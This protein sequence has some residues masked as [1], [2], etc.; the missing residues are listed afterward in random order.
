MCYH[1]GMTTNQKSKVIIV[2]GG[3][4]GLNA[5]QSLKRANVD[6]LVI[7]K[8]NHHLFQPLLYQVASAALSPGDI[9]VP[10]REVL[11]KQANATVILADVVMID[12][13]KRLVHA[14]NGEQY[15]Y[16]YLI[17]APGTTHSY[18]GHNHWEG[19]A[20]G[21]KTVADAIR[22]RERI[23]VAFELAEKSSNPDEIA[24]FLRFVIVGGGPTGCEMAGAIAEIAT[25][26]LFRNFRHINPELSEIYLIEGLPE[27]LPSFPP[28]LQLKAKQ[29]LEKLGVRVRL[30]TRV[31]DVTTE[32]IHIGNECLEA[33]NI[34]W[35]AGNQAP[36]LLKTLD[37]PLDRAGR[38][39][40]G[41]DLSIPQHPEIFVI[42][43]ASYNVD[44]NQKPLPGVAPVAIQQGRYVAKV[45]S[46]KDPSQRQP[47]CYWD[48][49]SMATIGKNKAV[50]TVGKLQISGILAWLAWSF[51]HVA[52]LVTFR[53]RLVVML[54]WIFLYFAGKRNVR[55]IISQHWEKF[56]KILSKK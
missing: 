54:Q 24:K 50:A 18:F 26:T 25:K 44:K 14:K 3:F 23:L 2:G 28:H 12:K 31:T 39:I 17:L 52:Y 5:A 8:T 46:Q 27:V 6:V 29:Q 21:L 11:A 55:L 37:V 34:I 9:A 7:D 36:S 49:G 51:I 4:G 41:P 42:G 43:D 20:P 1:E 47:F 30:N 40:T 10:I 15:P 56:E 19:F 32:G 35:A 48:K 33:F 22:I 13:H 38:V 16:D 45:I 53:N